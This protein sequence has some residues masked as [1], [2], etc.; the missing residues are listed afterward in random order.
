M[1]L[2]ENKYYR[3]KINHFGRDLDYQ[4]EVTKVDNEEFR[5]STEDDL[6]CRA[7]T[8]KMKDLRFFKEMPFPKKE[9]KVNFI[10]NKKQFTNLKYSD[11]PEGL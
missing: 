1:K 2:K 6:G 3:I 5:M 9:T 4:G 11:V 10:S 7:L 8:F